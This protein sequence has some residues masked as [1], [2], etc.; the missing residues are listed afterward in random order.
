L[1]FVQQLVK[2]GRLEVELKK[3]V[4]RVSEASLRRYLNGLKKVGG[5]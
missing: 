3:D 1:E 4:V 5:G 2:E